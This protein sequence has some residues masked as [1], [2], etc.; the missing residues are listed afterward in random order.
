MIL[1]DPKSRPGLTGSEPR[2]LALPRLVEQ[3]GPQLHSLARRF[4]PSPEDAEDLVQEV[5]LTA[6]RTWD[7]FRGDSKVSTWLYT[8]AS[9]ACMKMQRRK[10]GEPANMAS[11]DELMPMGE[12]RM[13]SLPGPGEDPLSEQLRAE[14]R[15]A[16]Q[17]AIADLPEAFRMPIVLREIV[18][19]TLADIAGVL[20][21]PEATV[22]TR[23]H[24]ARLRLR[25]ALEEN[26]PVREVPAYNLDKAI[27]MDLLQAKQASLDLGLTFEFPPGVFCERCSEVFKT[28]DL[29]QQFC[30]IAPGDEWP[31]ELG[32]QV[33]A[34]FQGA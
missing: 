20:Q 16:V 31:A 7:Q 19:L 21:I 1:P 12:P 32:R 26:L 30:S 11:L 2:D 13:A 9:R 14:G 23:L 18:G 17:Q 8:I 33:L 22:K 27:C 6:F 3:E 25:Q 10:V 24:R 28:M 34:S 29:T 5:F 15:A 4:C